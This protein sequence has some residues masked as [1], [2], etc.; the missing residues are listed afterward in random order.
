MNTFSQPRQISRDLHGVMRLAASF[1]KPH[2]RLPVH[3]D[4]HT[5]TCTP[6]RLPV[7]HDVHT[8]HETELKGE[9]EYQTEPIH[10]STGISH[11]R[12]PGFFIPGKLF[13]FKGGIFIQKIE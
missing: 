9:L 6:Q 4:V 11:G 12:I 8:V 13:I 5:V 7:Y 1:F 2:E 10:G 3:H